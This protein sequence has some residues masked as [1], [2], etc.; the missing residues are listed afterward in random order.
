MYKFNLCFS[1]YFKREKLELLS[2]LRNDSYALYLSEC[3][4]FVSK[5]VAI[6]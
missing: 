5:K 6:S 4:N 2:L 1:M 3:I